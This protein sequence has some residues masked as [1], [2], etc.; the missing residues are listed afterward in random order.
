MNA[1]HPPPAP[2]AS[3]AL[4]KIQKTAAR[5]ADLTTDEDIDTC[6]RVIRQAM[7]ATHRIFDPEH[8]RMIEVPDH[9]TRLAAATILL[10]Y[11]EGLP[12]KRTVALTG[13][14]QSADQLID[15]LRGS[16]EALRA[17]MGAG[18]QIEAD[19]RTVDFLSIPSGQH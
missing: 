16:P 1:S 9:K 5:L 15:R 11:D 7:N 10:A 18:V 2:K 17:I 12:I 8:R 13:D 19:G 4:K 6:L 3:A 14:F